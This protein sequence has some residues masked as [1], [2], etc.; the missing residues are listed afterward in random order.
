M[1]KCNLLSKTP[2]P[3]DN[4]ETWLTWAQGTEDKE[5]FIDV[6]HR[7]LMSKG[8]VFTEGRLISAG[9]RQPY[10]ST[11]DQVSMLSGRASG[12][13][14]VDGLIIGLDPDS[15]HAIPDFTHQGISHFVKQ[16]L[17]ASAQEKSFGNGAYA[18]TKTLHHILF[19]RSSNWRSSTNVHLAPEKDVEPAERKAISTLQNVRDQSGPCVQG[20]YPKRDRVTTNG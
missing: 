16:D 2:S 7:L 19:T 5:G 14:K 17:E 11:T 15:G 12:G 9:A 20:R 13:G 1:K 4:R 18:F 6:I 10:R 8:L 3:A